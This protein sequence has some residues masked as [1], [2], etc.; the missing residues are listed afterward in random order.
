MGDLGGTFMD[1]AGVKPVS[2]MT[3]QSLRPLLEGRKK[4]RPYIQSGLQSGDFNSTN[5]LDFVPDNENPNAGGFNWRM[6]VKQYNESTTLK[7]IC[8][9]E[10]CPGAPSN[11]PHPVD[12]W[13]QLLYN[14]LADPFDMKN[15]VND[16][17]IE[18][19]ELRALLPTV[20]WKCGKNS[21]ISKYLV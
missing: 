19:N 9:I 16:F 6:V 17:P 3:T 12:G 4:T 15:L 1:Y 7:F 8:C 5:L 2:G 21:S 18:A 10:T 14:T 20:H 13:T 11:V